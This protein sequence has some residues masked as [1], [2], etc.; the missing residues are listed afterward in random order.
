M[1]EKI[2]EKVKIIDF[3]VSLTLEIPNVFI[4]M[5]QFRIYG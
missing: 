4:F 5:L 3:I 1:L 2:L